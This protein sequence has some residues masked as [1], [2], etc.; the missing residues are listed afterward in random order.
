ME[1]S[2]ALALANQLVFLPGWIISAED[3]TNRFEGSIKVCFKYPTVQTER[4][5]A[6][7]NYPHPIEARASFAL[8][9]LDCDDTSIYRRILDAT[10]QIACHEHREALRVLPTYWAPFHP[11]RLDGM[12]RWGDVQ[13][14]MQ[15]G[16]V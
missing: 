3:H 2:S 11:H 10:V 14:D 16:L 4:A 7:D 1:V 13:G 12:N 8:P 5:D 9:V 6:P 15:F